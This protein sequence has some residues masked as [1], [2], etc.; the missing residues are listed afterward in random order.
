MSASPF[1]LFALAKFLLLPLDCA[2]GRAPVPTSAAVAE[3][4]APVATR[5]TF[6]V[7][8]AHGNRQD[9]RHWLRDDTREYPEILAY[10]GAEQA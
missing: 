7:T 8:S 4:H 1:H 3:K 2:H 5:D 9:A 10:L 6:T